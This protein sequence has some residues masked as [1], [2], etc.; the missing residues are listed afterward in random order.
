MIEEGVDAAAQPN[1]KVTAT[2]IAVL[3]EEQ[4]KELH[5]IPGAW[6][7]TRK[8]MG[9]GQGP[10]RGRSRAAVHGMVLAT[11]LVDWCHLL[12]CSRVAFCSDQRCVSSKQYLACLSS[13]YC[14]R[15]I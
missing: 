3:Y 9:Q 14:T 4:I 7:V 2:V 5:K 13:K 12:H 10:G 11:S 6:W 15:L 8:D 1:S